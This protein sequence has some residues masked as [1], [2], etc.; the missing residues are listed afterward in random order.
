[1]SGLIA[2]ALLVSFIVGNIQGENEVEYIATFIY[3]P[4]PET[5]QHTWK[6]DEKLV[7]S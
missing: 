3:S 2:A 5:A 6:F 4:G 1:M 7:Q